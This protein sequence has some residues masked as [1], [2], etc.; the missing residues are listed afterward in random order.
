MMCLIC[1]GP[2]SVARDDVH[3]LS[4]EHLGDERYE[5]LW[6]LDRQCHD[7]L[8]AELD[9]ARQWRHIGW[10]QASFIIATRLANEKAAA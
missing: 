9:R 4:Y 8:H 2:W 7:E 6:P 3:H 5:E 10:R 1:G